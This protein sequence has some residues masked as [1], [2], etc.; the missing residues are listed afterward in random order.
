MAALYHTDSD[1]A[2]TEKMPRYLAFGKGA[3]VDVTHVNFSH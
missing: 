3:S 1:L 2:E